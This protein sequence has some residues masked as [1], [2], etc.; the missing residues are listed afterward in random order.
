MNEMEKIETKKMDGIGLKNE[1]KYEFP[2]TENG[3]EGKMEAENMNEEYNKWEIAELG[4]IREICDGCKGEMKK[5]RTEKVIEIYKSL[6]KNNTHIVNDYEL[7]RISVDH[8]PIYY[9]LKKLNDKT[10][11]SIYLKTTSFEDRNFFNID[12]L[13][14]YDIEDNNA[15]VV[16]LRILD[17]SGTFEKLWEIE[18]WI[19]SCKIEFYT[20]NSLEISTTE[21]AL[22]GPPGDVLCLISPN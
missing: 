11:R 6:K 10:K 17:I 3:N 16:V 18:A 15:I 4:L 8:L 19:D 20:K 1:C 22:I 13:E 5:T 2:H 21:I 12:D 7:C 9:Q 14:E